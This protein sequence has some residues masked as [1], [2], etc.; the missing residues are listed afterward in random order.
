MSKH[1]LAKY[2]A[3]GVRKVTTGLTGLLFDPSMSALPIIETRRRSPKVSD[4]SS[5]NNVSWVWM[6]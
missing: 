6:S 4:C 3:R 1:G 2:S 5:A